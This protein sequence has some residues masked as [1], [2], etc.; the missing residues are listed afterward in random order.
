MMIMNV[1]AGKSYSVLYKA[2]FTVIV[3]YIQEQDVTLIEFFLF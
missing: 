2:T 3:F 1:F